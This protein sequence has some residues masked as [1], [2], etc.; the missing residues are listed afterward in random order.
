MGMAQVMNANAFYAGQRAS[1][2][3]LMPKAIP[4]AGAKDAVIWGNIVYCSEVALHHVGQHWLDQ[5][6]E[7]TFWNIRLHY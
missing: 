4:C 7:A 5:N 2:L 1:P 3:H 6:S